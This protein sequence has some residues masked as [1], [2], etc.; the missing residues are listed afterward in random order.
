MALHS[1][2]RLGGQPQNHS[3]EEWRV[4]DGPA[5]GRP[6][7]PEHYRELG[8]PPPV[9]LVQ[10]VKDHRLEALFDHAVCLLELTVRAGVRNSGPSDL[11]V[12]LIVE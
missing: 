12:I 5:R 3:H 10:S 1:Q 2:G 6:Q 4:A 11:D 7:T 8:D 9:K